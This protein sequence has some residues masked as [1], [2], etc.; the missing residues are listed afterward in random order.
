M[1]SEFQQETDKL[2][3]KAID[4]VDKT[5]DSASALA[6]KKDGKPKIVADASL[7]SAGV[8]ATSLTIREASPRAASIYLTF[9]KALDSRLE[10]KFMSETG[11]EIGRA[12]QRVLATAG[13]GRFVDFPIDTRTSIGEIRTIS[14]RKP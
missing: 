13:E 7:Q 11:A 6:T 1:N 3:K 8:S 2:V 14:V 10:A 12:Q 5:L 4:S 9:E